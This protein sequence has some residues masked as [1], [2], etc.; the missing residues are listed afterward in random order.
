MVYVYGLRHP[1]TKMF[2]YVGQ[3]AYPRNRLLQHLAPSAHSSGIRDWVKSL[4]SSGITPEVCVLEECSLE[5]AS[6]KEGEWIASLEANGHPLL[7]VRG[8]LPRYTHTWSI[9]LTDRQM[10]L[11]EKIA[12][13]EERDKIDVVRDAIEAWA[14][15]KGVE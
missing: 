3:T 14:K 8:P 4:R 5:D 1:E 7:N 15:Q 10:A 13:Q 9:R 2:A 12:E 6:V 11:I